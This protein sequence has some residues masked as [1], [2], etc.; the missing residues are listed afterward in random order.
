[1][2]KILDANFLIYSLLEDHPASKVCEKL[3][4]SCEN[5][6][7]WITSPITLIETFYVLIKIYGQKIEDVYN[8]IKAIVKLPLGIVSLDQ[9]LVISALDKRIRHQIDIN[10]AILLQ[11]GIEIGIP[12]IATDDKRLAKAVED[13]GIVCEN[14]ITKEIRQEMAEWERINL[15]EKGI[16]RIYKGVHKWLEDKD[17]SIADEFKS[18][19]KGLT[20]M[21]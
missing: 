7:D 17:K 12:I 16:A 8:K 14:P 3:I 4:L 6:F 18:L 20:R 1:M 2:K 9:L 10:D 11:I 15:P 13:Y 19:T 21:L 5:K